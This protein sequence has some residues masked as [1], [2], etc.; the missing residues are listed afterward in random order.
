[1]IL[2]EFADTDLFSDVSV[3]K[4]IEGATRAGMVES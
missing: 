1:M 4:L 3:R 2:D